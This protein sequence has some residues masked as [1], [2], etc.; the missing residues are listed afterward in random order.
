MGTQLVLGDEALGFCLEEKARREKYVP[1]AA[2][3]KELDKDHWY[4]CRHR[5]IN[6]SCLVTYP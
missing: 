6:L 5:T 3:Q 1:T 2:E 4:S